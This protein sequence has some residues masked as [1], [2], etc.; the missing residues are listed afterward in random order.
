MKLQKSRKMNHKEQIFYILMVV[1]GIV[2][3]LVSNAIEVRAIGLIVLAW[4]MITILYKAGRH[5]EE[6]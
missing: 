6:R 3:V 5:Y 4:S 1:A 2:M